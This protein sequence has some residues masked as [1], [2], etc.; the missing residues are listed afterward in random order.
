VHC[1]NNWLAFGGRVVRRANNWLAPGVR[2]GS[3]PNGEAG[4]RLIGGGG[5]P[6]GKKNL[7]SVVGV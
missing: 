3:V 4:G 5:A 2:A 6:P 1:A 7:N